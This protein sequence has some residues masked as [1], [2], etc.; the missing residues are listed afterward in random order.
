MP[1]PQ[2]AVSKVVQCDR[3]IVRTNDQHINKIFSLEK[4]FFTY[5]SSIENEW[6]TGKIRAI[7]RQAN[8]HT[9]VQARLP[10][11]PKAPPVNQGGR[12]QSV[13]LNRPVAETVTSSPVIKPL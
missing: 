4:K 2:L 3:T 6:V 11:S 7:S 8:P 12:F 9:S 10:S 13:G 5:F 1:L